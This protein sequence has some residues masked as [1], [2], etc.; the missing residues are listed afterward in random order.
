MSS[1]VWLIMA[2]KTRLQGLEATVEQRCASLFAFSMVSPLCVPASPTVLR[3]YGEV[4]TSWASR[5]SASPRGSSPQSEHAEEREGAKHVTVTFCKST[6][7]AEPV[8]R[9]RAMLFRARRTLHFAAVTF[10]SRCHLRATAKQAHV[11]V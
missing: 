10:Q 4:Q 2:N 1:Q 11:P 9:A 3:Q 7:R 6:G 5:R 8:S